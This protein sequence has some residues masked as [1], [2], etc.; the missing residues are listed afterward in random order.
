MSIHTSI[1]KSIQMAIHTCVHMFVH[2]SIRISI[3]IC[4]LRSD[5]GETVDARP[6]NGGVVMV[7]DVA[8]L[9]EVQQVP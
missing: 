1:H 3:D 4:I 8:Q 6:G 9:V 5:F 2:T 7:L